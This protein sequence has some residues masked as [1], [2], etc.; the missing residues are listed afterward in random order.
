MTPLQGAV[1]LLWPMVKRPSDSTRPGAPDLGTK[2]WLCLSSLQKKNRNGEISKDQNDFHSLSWV[3]EQIPRIFL[4]VFITETQTRTQTMDQ[5]RNLCQAHVAC[6][7]KGR[8]ENV[9]NA[10]KLETGYTSTPG[11]REIS[12]GR[13][14]NQMEMWSNQSTKKLQ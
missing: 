11:A 9:V 2:D 12:G 13:K 6:Q 1:C 4:E 3:P 10:Q 8:K 5:P 14:R 7:E